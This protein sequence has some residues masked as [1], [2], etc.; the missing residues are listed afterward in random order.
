MIADGSERHRVR[1]QDPEWLEVAA[2]HEAHRATAG[3]IA[4][5]AL[6]TILLAVLF[7]AMATSPATAADYDYAPETEEM[8]RTACMRA[9]TP[10]NCQCMME[11]LQRHLGLG[12]FLNAVETQNHEVLARAATVVREG[13]GRSCPSVAGA[14]GSPPAS[15]PPGVETSAQ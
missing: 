10:A 9:D 11:A 3:A 7:S 6:L 1:S 5:I 8:Y 2:R 15:D 12:G 4:L 14:V 13:K